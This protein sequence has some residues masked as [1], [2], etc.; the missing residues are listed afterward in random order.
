[1]RGLA[2]SSARRLVRTA[3]VLSIAFI[4]SCVSRPD[5]DRP[6]TGDSVPTVS[7]WFVERA[8]EAGLDFVHVNGMSGKFY[9]AE[10]FSPGVALFDFDND[11]DLDVYIVQGQMLGDPGLVPAVPAAG[12]R[13]PTG[14]LFRNDLEV[15]AD[16]TRV[17]RFVDRTET[18][19]LAEMRSYGMGAA[20]GDFDRDGCV[21]LYVTAL[22]PNRLF[23]NG[24]DGTF[25]DVSKES[26]TDDPSW[27]VSAAF[28]DYDRDGWLDLFVG[29][30]LIYT[31]EDNHACFGLAGQRD[32]CRPSSYRPQR[33]RLYHN[34]RNGRFTDV[35]D[36]AL[37]G[38]DFGPALGVSTADF[39]G[40]SWIDIFVA[41]D[42]QANQL[43]INQHDGTFRNTGLLAGVAL[44]NDG[45]ATAGM[46][47][48]AGDF[49]ND[50]DEDLVYTNLVGEGTRLVVNDGS[51]TFEDEGARSGMH[52]RSL[53]HTG[54]GTAWFD[55]DNDGWLDVLTVNGA[56]RI[57]E[58]L[59]R[60]KDPFPFH[61]GK[62]LFRNLGNRRFDDVTKSAGRAFELSEVGRGA[63]FGDVDNDGDI[64]VVVGNNNG[65]ARLLVNE[66]GRRNHWLG[67]RLTDA[68]GRLDRLGARV[69]I[70]RPDTA[71]WRRARADGSYA[72]ANDSRVVVGL[73]NF[74]Q[75]VAVRVI[76]P[77]GQ[78]ETWSD[79]AID[80]YSTLKEGS[81]R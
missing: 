56:V 43:W 18:S 65:R 5:G 74:D 31:V 41:N 70:T 8:E 34:D 51:G 47:V 55:F 11:G 48:D 19:G 16:G 46:G 27:S 3:H 37:V 75:P 9:D 58:A 44:N 61:E 26:R 72:S 63:A 77:N 14:R 2:V 10:I 12:T 28:V 53:P 62:Q 32:Y 66:V 17:L 40:D 57:I 79:I 21:D 4:L 45:F 1:M 38:G 23:R 60:T 25:T 59:A 69:A 29:N 7:E 54:F 35:T 81:G 39:N 67:L 78:T 22:G 49:D 24:C 76:W 15:R 33:S 64:D 73:G 30:Y 80:R 42:G 52:L 71:I 13:P 20:T 6:A 50:G 36:L 68:T